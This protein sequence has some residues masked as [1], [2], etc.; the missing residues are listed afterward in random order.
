MLREP[1]TIFSTRVR[2]TLRALDFWL[3]VLLKFE[4]SRRFQTVVNLNRCSRPVVSVAA[5]PLTQVPCATLT[6]ILDRPP[7]IWQPA[8]FKHSV[9][10]AHDVPP[11]LAPTKLGHG[12]V[13]LAPLRALRQ[14]FDAVAS[15]RTRG[16]TIFNMSAAMITAPRGLDALLVS[17]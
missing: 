14:S 5:G 17:A 16:F 13:S 11:P 2:S 3:S 9:P 10:S 15:T 7:M 8:F 12:D 4:S 1:F 6:A